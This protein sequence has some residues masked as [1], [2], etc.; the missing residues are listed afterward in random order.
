[1]NVLRGELNI[2]GPRSERLE[3]V[4]R[5]TNDIPGCLQRPAVLPGI[6]GLAQVI[7]RNT[8]ALCPLVAVQQNGFPAFPRA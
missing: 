4:E 7:V 6:T 3:F 8:R 1:M 2:V 5:V